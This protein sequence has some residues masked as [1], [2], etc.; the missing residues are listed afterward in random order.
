MGESPWG[1]PHGGTPPWGIPPWGI[2][3]AMIVMIV[4][5]SVFVFEHRPHHQLRQAS[6]QNRRSALGTMPGLLGPISGHLGWGQAL[7]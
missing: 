2:P 7:A 3:L 5:I 1:I 4:C 6:Q